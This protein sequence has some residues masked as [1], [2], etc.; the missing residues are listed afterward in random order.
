MKPLPSSSTGAKRFNWSTV[1]ASGGRAALS[2]RRSTRCRCRGPD[3]VADGVAVAGKITDKT[4]QA[5]NRAGE[6][7]AVFG[8]G[9]HHVLRLS[10]SFSTAWSL[11]ATSLEN[12]EVFDSSDAG[13]GPDP[14][15]PATTPRQRVHVMRIQAPDNGLQAAEQQIEI[16]RPRC[17][18][19]EY[20][21]PAAE[22]WSIPA[23]DQFEV[24]V[25]DQVEV[26]DGRFGPRRECDLT[27]GVE[28]DQD[29]VVRLQ[30]HGVDRADPNSG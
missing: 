11:L 26:A 21:I 27:V 19:A 4:L 2:R 12:D 29:G 16:Q 8:K 6:L 17:W 30:R 3:G 13:S 20:A 14:G 22:S 7:I 5:I 25:P 15:R 28:F 23:D 10:I 9:F 24:A 18:S 1:P